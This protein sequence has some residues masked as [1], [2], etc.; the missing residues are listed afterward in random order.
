[1]R[2]LGHHLY[3]SFGGQR[4]VYLSPW[5]EGLR[6]LLEQRARLAYATPGAFDGVHQG[7]RWIA[8]FSSGNGLDHVGRPRTLVHQLVV[9][10]EQAPPVFSPLLLRSAALT[11]L[12]HDNPAIGHHLPADLDALDLRAALPAP[13]D[14]P[15]LLAGPARVLAHALLRALAEPGQPVREV[16]SD[17]PALLPDFAAASSLVLVHAPPVQITSMPQPLPVPEPQQPLAVLAL[18]SGQPR[19]GGGAHETLAWH[20]AADLAAEAVL[21]LIAEAPQPPRVLFL[22]RRIPL[23]R[24]LASD[25]AVELHAS[26]RQA[27]VGFD[28]DGLPLM[29]PTDPASHRVLAVLQRAEAWELVSDILHGWRNDL[30]AAGLADPEWVVACDACLAHPRLAGLERLCERLLSP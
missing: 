11:R 25:I 16:V 30:I 10:S 29:P 9:A 8:T 22:L 18:S 1:M 6:G 12:E 4:T 13:S 21:S 5:L 28:R 2:P 19:H 7:G 3:T 14:L 20:S 26:L 27:S 17:L 24:L 23:P 15:R